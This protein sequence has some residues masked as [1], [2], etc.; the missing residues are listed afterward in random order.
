MDN[1]CEWTGAN[2][3]QRR[4][5]EGERVLKAGHVIKCGKNTDHASSGEVSV[6]AFCL[7]TSHLRDKPHEINIKINQS[8]GKNYIQ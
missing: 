1:I 3:S 6:K 7:Q 8:R 5:V 2:P 4:F